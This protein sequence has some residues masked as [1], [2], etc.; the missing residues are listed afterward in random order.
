MIPGVAPI[1]NAEESGRMDPLVMNPF[2]VLTFLA[3][4]AILS[5]G[6]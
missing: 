3:A 5:G 6:R 4:P 1:W 2:T